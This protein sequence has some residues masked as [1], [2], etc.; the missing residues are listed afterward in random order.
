MA[1]P[2]VL[3]LFAS[4]AAAATAARA[5]HDAGVSRDDISVLSRSHDEEGALAEQMDASPG[6]DIED[7]RAAARLG[8]LSGQVLAAIA[9]VLAGHRPDRRRRPALGRAR[10]SGRPRGR[11]PGVGAEE[12]RS[13]GRTGPI[14][15]CAISSAAACCWRSMP[16]PIDLDTIRAGPGLSPSRASSTSS[17]G[18]SNGRGRPPVP[19]GAS[20]SE[21]A[22]HLPQSFLDRIERFAGASIL[23]PCKP[24]LRQPQ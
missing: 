2:L 13:P 16:A 9:V 1:H 20:Y 5:L 15:S 10:R 23:H 21:D 8:E 3:A 22:W 6:V 14:T 17:T 11:R 4:P 19:A 12:R 18:R 7:S 24:G